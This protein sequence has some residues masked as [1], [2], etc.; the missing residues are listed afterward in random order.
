[1]Q[2][3]LSDSKILLATQPVDFRKSINGLSEIVITD[4]HSSPKDTIFIFHNRA[5][6]KLKILLWHGNGFILLYKRLEQGRFV[7]PR[8]EAIETSALNEKQLNWLLAGLD[9][10][11]MAHFK[12]LSYDDCF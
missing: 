4:Y 10:Y 6:D 7:V 8:G 11:T 5:K 9:W 1:M 3:N 12:E 2:L